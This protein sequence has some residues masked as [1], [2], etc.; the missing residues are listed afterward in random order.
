MLLVFVSH[1]H[2]SKKCGNYMLLPFTLS[3]VKAPT[4]KNYAT[5]K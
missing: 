2:F 5:N 1:A 4:T 3:L